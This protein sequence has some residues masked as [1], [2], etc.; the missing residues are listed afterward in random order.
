[1]LKSKFSRFAV[2]AIALTVILIVF[3]VG[4]LFP[5]LRGG[6][7]WR[8]PYVP[9]ALVRMLPLI[10]ATVVYIVGAARC[11]RSCHSGVEHRWI[12]RA[13]AT[14]DLGALRQPGLR[15]VC[16]HRLAPHVGAA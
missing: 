13:D 8:W 1:M 10:I 2:F 6:F 5:Y 3:L 15:T 12:A 4:D 7:G 14:R 11:P 16:A 9:V